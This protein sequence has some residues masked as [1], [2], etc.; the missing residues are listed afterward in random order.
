MLVSNGATIAFYVTKISEG[1]DEDHLPATSIRDTIHLLDMRQS[2]AQRT[3]VAI[4]YGKWCVVIHFVHQ[5]R[6]GGGPRGSVQGMSISC[7]GRSGNVNQ[8]RFGDGTPVS[9][10]HVVFH[11]FGFHI[12][13]GLENGM[14]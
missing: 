2:Q 8:G 5:V 1:I 7:R 10:G 9:P 11:V 14:G 13:D 12:K 4:R 3:H 6:F